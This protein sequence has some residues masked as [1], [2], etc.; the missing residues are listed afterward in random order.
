M[1]NQD[2]YSPLQSLIEAPFHI[3][4]SYL[5][6]VWRSSASLADLQL[7]T[8]KTALASSAVTARQYLPLNDPQDWLNL[9][10][11]ESRFALERLQAHGRELTAVAAP[12]QG[13]LSNPGRK[14][15]E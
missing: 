1:L 15:L 2:K 8:L 3:F 10:A 7:D 9:A 4:N 5:Q 11:A 6:A 13:F 12:L 14:P